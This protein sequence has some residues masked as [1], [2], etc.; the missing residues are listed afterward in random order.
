MINKKMTLTNILLLILIIYTFIC[1][2]IFFYQR[3]LLY[4]PGENNYLD[5]G[6]LN[7]KIEKVFINSE[8]SLVGWHFQKNENYKT[9]LLFHG[10]A[11]KLDNRIYKLNEFSKMNV[12]YLIFAYRGFSGNDGKPSEIGLYEDALA[13]KKW[14]NSKKIEDKNIILYGESLGTAIALNL[15]QDYSFSGVILESPFTS[16]ETLAKSY[17]P[18]L[19]VKYLLKDKYNSISKLNKNTSPIL[20]MH[21]MK[22]K[23][24]Q[25]L[26]NFIF[27]K[28]YMERI[29]SILIVI[30]FSNFSYAEISNETRNKYFYVGKMKSYNSQFTLYFKTRDKAILA[31]GEDANYINDYPQDLYIYNHNSKEDLPLL[32]YEWFP[33]KVKK[34]V[35]NYT[36]PVFPEDFAYYLMKDNNTLILVSGKKNFHQ[37][38]EYNIQSKKLKNFENDGKL[39]FIISSYA[40]VCGYEINKNNF[41]CSIEKPLI[42]KNLIN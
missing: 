1:I 19:P 28:S 37:N 10:N 2:F 26:S 42:S 18:Y 8:S 16:M 32:T 17:Y 23:I 38:L 25:V 41:E 31:R 35:K 6:P 27:L 22:D 33:K 21:G 3:N 40:K 5:E 7:H 15:A 29:L 39:N 36:Y 14:L 12:N 20:V 34:L 4:H 24:K 30:F 11:G 9:I 13:A